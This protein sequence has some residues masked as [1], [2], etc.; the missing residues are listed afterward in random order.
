[1]RR[2]SHSL[3]VTS[4]QDPDLPKILDGDLLR[5]QTWE[6]P[7]SY[8]DV[9]E[10]ARAAPVLH[11]IAETQWYVRG[12]LCWLWLAATELHRSRVG[13]GPR[14]IPTMLTPTETAPQVDPTS[15]RYTAINCGRNPSKVNEG[16]TKSGASGR[17]TNWEKK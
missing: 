13:R 17:Y 4:W 1:M 2:R 10:A 11:N 16:R 15:A 7:P 12:K 14:A 6:L 5:E 9:L 8:D 3:G